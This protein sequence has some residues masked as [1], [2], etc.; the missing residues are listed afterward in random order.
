[1][2]SQNVLNIVDTAMVSSLGDS[3]LAAVGLA[4]FA[5]FMCTAFIMGA[6]TGVQAT[7]ARW[8][9]AGRTHEVAIPLNGGLLLALLFG[10]PV[11]VILYMLAPLLFSLL[12]QDADVAA[13]GGT[14]RNP[15]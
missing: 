13:L 9:G 6:A 10:L 8:L 11:S 7:A 12:S 2:V 14:Y 15:K 3:A 4:G 5:G 1:M